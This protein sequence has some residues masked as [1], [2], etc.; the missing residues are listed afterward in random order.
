MRTIHGNAGT[1]RWAQPS[2]CVC[3]ERDPEQT[4]GCWGVPAVCS[5]SAASSPG[6]GSRRM[7]QLSIIL[8][9]KDDYTG[10]EE[11]SWWCRVTQHET[12][13]FLIKAWT[14]SPLRRNLVFLNGRLMCICLEMREQSHGRWLSL[15]VCSL[16]DLFALPIIDVFHLS[17]PL[18]IQGS[19]VRALSVPPALLHEWESELVGS[20]SRSWTWKWRKSSERNIN[21]SSW[22]T[23]S[24]SLS[25][26]KRREPQRWTVFIM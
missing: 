26:T 23:D 9:I 10:R 24:G 25:E 11:R 7:K 1:G 5:W 22:G 8:D 2:Q 21:Q 16:K 4:E 20:R 3:V 6:Q 12:F 13:R 18:V 17:A 14:I 19:G 15:D